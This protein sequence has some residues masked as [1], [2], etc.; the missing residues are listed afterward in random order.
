MVT[1]RCTLPKTVGTRELK[2]RLGTYLRL[3]RSGKTLVV[4]DRGRPVAEIRPIS[5]SGDPRRV[6]LAEM[7]ALGLVTL[8]K[9]KWRP[10]RFRPV[11]ILSG[12]PLSETLRE[13]REDRI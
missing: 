6:A 8:P 2:T 4:T 12:P 13:M 11:R 3:V 10:A 9:R 1:R 7:A 5:L